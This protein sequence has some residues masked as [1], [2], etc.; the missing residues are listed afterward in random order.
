MQS[1]HLIASTRADGYTMCLLV[2]PHFLGPSAAT[3]ACSTAKRMAAPKQS[4]LIARANVSMWAS[5]EAPGDKT[6][7]SDLL[8]NR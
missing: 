3:R 5:R 8:R 4:T 2:R 7:V 1:L 6:G